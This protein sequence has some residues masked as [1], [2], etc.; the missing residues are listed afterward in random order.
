MWLEAARTSG[1]PTFVALANGLVQ[2][3]EA[4]EAGLRLPGSSG[5]I[6][7]HSNRLKLVKRVGYGRAR[8]ELLRIRVLSV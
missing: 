3:R 1:L 7:G 8:F 4:V 5:V 2:A 6:E